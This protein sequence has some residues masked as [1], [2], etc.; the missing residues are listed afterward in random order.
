LER[1]IVTFSRNVFIPLTDFCRNSCG[2]CCFRRNHLILT[3]GQVE[4]I[5]EKGLEMGCTEALF[6]FGERPEEVPGF[7]ERLE[8]LGYQDMVSYLWDMCRL[9][10]EI[11]LLPHSNP[12]VLDR[13]ELETLGEVNASMG[14]MLET[15][16]RVEAH[17]LSPGKNP[18][19]RLEVLRNAGRLK[20]PFTTGL[21]LGIGETREDRIRSLV[22]IARVQRRYGNIQEVIIQNFTPKPNTP[23]AAWKPP[24]FAEIEDTV[25]LA[26]QILPSDVSI[27]VP[28]NLNQPQGL[29]RLLEKG[30]NDLG[31]I[32]P[33]TIDYI[34]PEARWP[35]VDEIESIL[36][37]GW[38][39]RERLAI[40]PRYIKKGWYSKRVEPLIHRYA[41]KEGYKNIP[42]TL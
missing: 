34:N 7:R 10:L 17:R 16:A 2:Y 27:Q 19:V 15:T 39:L 36:P 26:R 22:E 32:S 42:T 38:R 37:G 28:P 24:G 40:Y 23:M 31:G 33:V 13:G 41:D 12:G 18:E 8:T 5:L 30:V 11:G 4:E 9:A 3:P 25:M 29:K 35:E 1:H 21:L 6:T 14:L 20:I